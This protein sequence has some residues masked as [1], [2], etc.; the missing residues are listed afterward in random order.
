MNA[1]RYGAIAAAATSDT[2][3]P[4][5]RISTDRSRKGERKSV[6]LE[7]VFFV[8]LDFQNLAETEILAPLREILLPFKKSDEFELEFKIGSNRLL[9]IADS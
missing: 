9:M 8:G 7:R 3:P 4:Q 5:L 6:N 1:K 2:A